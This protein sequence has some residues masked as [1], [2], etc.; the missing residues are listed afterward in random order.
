MYE[1]CIYIH[2]KEKKRKEYYNN[3]YKRECVPLFIYIHDIFIGKHVIKQAENT[4][5]AS[6]S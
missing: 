2:E 1:D 5:T 4:I 3:T 6:I